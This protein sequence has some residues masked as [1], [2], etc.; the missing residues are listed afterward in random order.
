VITHHDRDPYHYAWKDIEHLLRTDRVGRRAPRWLGAS[1]RPADG[2]GDDARSASLAAPARPRLQ[3]GLLG[4]GL[5]RSRRRGRSPPHF[6]G[7]AEPCLELVGVGEELGQIIPM[8]ALHPDVPAERRVDF[9]VRHLVAEV[10]QQLT[11]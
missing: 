5:D 10:T 3:R 8:D 7:I 6:E 1:A 4:A 11:E 2:A 9:L